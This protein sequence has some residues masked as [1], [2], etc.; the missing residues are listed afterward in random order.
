M[1][2][3]TGMRK[4]RWLRSWAALA[5]LMMAAC[6]GQL[7]QGSSGPSSL[8]NSGSPPSPAVGSG[9]SSGG[10]ESAR[11]SPTP[12]VASPIPL[13]QSYNPSPFACASVGIPI[14]TTL[15]AGP[16]VPTFDVRISGDVECHW[17]SAVRTVEVDLSTSSSSLFGL[18]EGFVDNVP[19]VADGA[20]F[21]SAPEGTG[22]SEFVALKGSVGVSILVISGPNALPDAA[23]FRPLALQILNIAA[24]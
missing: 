2:G 16:V 19:G 18:E 11:P 21:I 24:P 7:P 10:Q 13:N 12:L 22:V 20:M 17:Q 8:S 5:L 14:V 23:S 3:F 9:L 6:S 4:W 15:A 1:T